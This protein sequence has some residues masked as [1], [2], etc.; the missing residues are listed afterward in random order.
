MLALS[1]K[2]AN[3]D[4]LMKSTL[5]IFMMKKGHVDRPRRGI[6]VTSR[7]RSSSPTN[8]NAR[9]LWSSQTNP[10]KTDLHQANVL[11]MGSNNH[12]NST[13]LGHVGLIKSLTT[14]RS[15]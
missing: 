2:R 12:F 7:S 11:D 6:M 4:L 15:G 1:R 9:Y 14:R 8:Q 3:E 13:Q 5:P 10:I